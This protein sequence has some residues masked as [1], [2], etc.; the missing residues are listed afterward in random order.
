MIDP[1][2]NLNCIYIDRC[3][4]FQNREL[5]IMRRLNH[6]NVV[7]LLYFFYS[8]GDKKDEVY[9]NLIL[10][11]VP[12]TWALFHIYDLCIFVHRFETLE[13]KIRIKY[14][15]MYL[16]NLL[17][18]NIPILVSFNKTTLFS[19]LGCTEWQGITW[20]ICGYFCENL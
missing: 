1:Q 10:E 11:Y 16:I 5:Q 8:N 15:C 9:L 2:L 13:S 17:V 6:R 4:L 12:E 20:V 3:C 19:G 14:Y 7:K 18:I